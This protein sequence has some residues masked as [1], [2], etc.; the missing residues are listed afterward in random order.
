VGLQDE[1]GLFEQPLLKVFDLGQE[2]DDLAGDAP[3][4]L[5]AGQ[6]ILNL[7]FT[8]LIDIVQAHD[9]VLQIEI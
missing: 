3:D 8:G 7:A 4:D 9:L 5:K 1:L 6:V 2:G